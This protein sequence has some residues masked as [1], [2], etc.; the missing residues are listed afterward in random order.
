MTVGDAFEGRE[1]NFD[2]LR[3]VAAVLVLVSHSYPLTG[4]GNEPFASYLGFDTGG[5]WGVAIF[6]VISGFLVTR[7]V[8]Q[9]RVA[10]YLKSRVLRIVPA[11]LVVSLFEA[12]CIGTLFTSL[13]LGKYFG[14]LNTWDHVLNTLVFGLNLSL[15]GVF[16]GNPNRLVNG[17]LWTLP[18]EC[19]F[20]LMLPFLAFLGLLSAKRYLVLPFLAAL[21][22]AGGIL[23]FAWSW[24]NQGGNAFLDVPTYSALKNSIFFLLG[25]ALW[26]YRRSMPL[27]GGLA[28]CCLLLLS[29]SGFSDAKWVVFFLAVPYLTIYFALVRPIEIAW[30]AKLGDISYG[31]YIYAFPVQQALVHCFGPNIGPTSLTLMALPITLVLA[32]L[33]WV[34]VERRAIALRKAWL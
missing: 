11:L 23:F 22:F 1:N 33:S 12:F 7:S 5:G 30:Y 19:L 9:R 20:Y 13:P 32:T 3:I 16:E 26:V 21:A 18:I 24:D 27:D 15:P 10:D 31:T 17:S 2:L 25:G 28:L 14:D 8:L 4:T 6:F 29:I 34:L